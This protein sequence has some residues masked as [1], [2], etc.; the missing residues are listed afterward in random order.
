MC[1]NK[2]T[3]SRISP[4]IRPPRSESR[5]WKKAWLIASPTAW[6]GLEF[7]RKL[8]AR[9]A[10]MLAT[11]NKTRIIRSPYTSRHR[12]EN[13]DPAAAVPKLAGFTSILCPAK[14]TPEV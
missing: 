9:N 13:S 3:N 8:A 11:S 7:T 12:N 4:G 1:L 14:P 10:S 2:S 6:P 5:S